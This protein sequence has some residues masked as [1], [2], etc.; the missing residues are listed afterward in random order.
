MDL[1]CRLDGY[2]ATIAIRNGEGVEN[3]NIPIIAVTADVMES[4]ITCRR[5]RNEPLFI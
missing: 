1:K 2:E 3:A 5:N 4:K